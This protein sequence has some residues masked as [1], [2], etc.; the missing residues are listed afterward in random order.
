MIT[1]KLA[2]DELKNNPNFSE[3]FDQGIALLRRSGIF[4]F[5]RTFA[6]PFIVDAGKDIA[7]AASQASHSNGYHN[8]LDDLI[9]FK[10]LYIKPEESRRN[11]RLDFGGIKTAI[12]KGDL[13]ESEIYGKPTGPTTTTTKRTTK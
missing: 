7:S 10:Q 5:L 11:I 9:Y 3:N 13:L 8:A 12:A 2:L 6:R 4:D 1:A